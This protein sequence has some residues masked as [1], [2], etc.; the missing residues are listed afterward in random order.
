MEIDRLTQTKAMIVDDSDE[1]RRIMKSFIADLIDEFVDCKN[2]RDAFT[3]YAKHKP[4]V[5][6]MDLEMKD[7]DGI[8][9]TRQIKT[10]YPSAKVIIVSQSDSPA[11]RASAALVHANG[12]IN[13][14]DLLP[15]RA[16]LASVG[17]GKPNPRE[18][19]HGS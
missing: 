16:L 8:T 9:A 6:L 1:V 17:I 3:L 18:G 5:V 7:I 11:L 13:K 19:W 14:E 15:L 4:S 12:Y 10:A 2:G